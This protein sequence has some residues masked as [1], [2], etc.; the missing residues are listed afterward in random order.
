[1]RT[2]FICFVIYIVLWK[3]V[4]WWLPNLL[5]IPAMLI[6]VI[7][8]INNY[9]PEVSAMDAYLDEDEKIQNKAYEYQQGKDEYYDY[10]D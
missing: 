9:S 3:V 5:L 7:R 4:G 8:H 6:W 1:M 10:Q 2:I